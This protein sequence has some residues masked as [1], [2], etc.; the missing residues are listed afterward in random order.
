MAKKKSKNATPVDNRGINYPDPCFHCENLELK[1]IG[2]SCKVDSPAFWGDL[3]G[4]ENNPKSKGT[5]G[6]VCFLFKQLPKP[7]R[8]S[9]V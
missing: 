3:Q 2:M 8:P 9:M 4:F 1:S 7:L 5:P 6:P